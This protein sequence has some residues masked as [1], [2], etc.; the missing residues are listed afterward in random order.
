MTPE[1]IAV[2]LLTT[3]FGLLVIFLIGVWYGRRQAE[4]RMYR[5]HRYRRPIR[6]ARQAKVQARR[7]I[8][9][10]DREADE[11][12]DAMDEVARRHLINKRRGGNSRR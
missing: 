7:E 2:V 4:D 10:L 12:M 6:N 5:S 1:G 3:F 9:W 11:A 8:E